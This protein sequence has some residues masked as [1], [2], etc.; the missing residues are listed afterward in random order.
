MSGSSQ[1]NQNEAVMHTLEY[2]LCVLSRRIEVETGSKELADAALSLA[3]A[4]HAYVP[5]GEETGLEAMHADWHRR[6]DKLM[7]GGG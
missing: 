4:S 7:H 2:L 1:I 5:E 6:Y 3:S